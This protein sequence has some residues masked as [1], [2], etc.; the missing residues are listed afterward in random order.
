MNKSVIFDV[1]NHIVSDD[2]L[3]F[4]RKHDALAEEGYAQPNWSLDGMLEHMEKSNIAWTLL[5]LSTP[6]P[7][8]GDA[9]ESAA[10]CREMNEHLARIR[11]DHRDCI[12]F[13]AVIPLPDVDA[14]ID[15]AIYALDTLGANSIKF[16]S[17]SRGLYL[18]DPSLD[19][20]FEEL[21][22]R[23]AV[24]NIHPHLAKP[25]VPNVFTTR[26]VPVFEF[27]VD[28][29]RTVLNMVANNLLV[30]YPNV[31]MIIPHCGS[32][33]PSATSRFKAITPI[34]IKRG[35]LPPIDIDD[36]LSR[37]YFDLAGA[38]VPNLISFLLTITT[39]EKMMFGGDCPHT[40]APVVMETISQLTEFIDEDPELAPYKDMIFYKNA[41]KLFN[42]DR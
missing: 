7:Y 11:D 1:H 5:S 21:N 18:G 8:F 30:R 41:Q 33:L 34:A 14:G 3:E 9:A 36:N 42:L 40:P 26:F 39:P 4:L 37:C 19:P 25:A 10:F 6:H 20:L 16:A 31:K 13:S 17:N 24:A 15:E 23:S 2:F 38:P 29:T 32:Y 22:K 27:I 12:G 28:T 35:E